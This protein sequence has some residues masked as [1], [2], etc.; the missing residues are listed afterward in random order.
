MTLRLG[1]DS[2]ILPTEATLVA[3]SSVS[4]K[5][6]V[7]HAFK[8]L[9][10][11][12]PVQEWSAFDV[13]L[14]KARLG[15]V[16]K[17]LVTTIWNYHN[18][19]DE[20]GAVCLNTTDETF[21]YRVDNPH[22]EKREASQ[23]WRTH[24][25]RLEIARSEGIPIIGVLKDI[26]TKDCSWENI[27]DIDPKQIKISDK[28]M[29]LQ[30]KPRNEVR[31]PVGVIDIEEETKEETTKSLTEL[32]EELF[33]AVRW[34]IRSTALERQERLAK[35]PKLPKSIKVTTTVFIRNPDVVAEVLDRAEGF[36]KKCGEQAPFLRKANDSPYLEVHHRK[37][38]AEGGEDTVENA[39]AMCPNCHRKAHYGKA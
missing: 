11:L 23:Q 9:G 39:I 24:W 5:M 12:A 25:N 34:A 35:A 10:A 37:P 27:F 13:P 15:G 6:G 19:S 28:K 8:K 30:L 36:C 4:F 21:W 31:F 7:N 29:W 18:K 17:L 2:K 26:H 1:R 20:E 38:L 33:K 14:D 22:V 16:A 3:N 32:N